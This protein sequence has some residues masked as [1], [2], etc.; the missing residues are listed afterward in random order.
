[1]VRGSKVKRFWYTVSNAF[2]L[3]VS[4]TVATALFLLLP[5]TAMAGPEVKDFLITDVTPS[6]FSVVWTSGECGNVAVTSD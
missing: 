3:R 6:A 5:V 4:F 1:M 2:F